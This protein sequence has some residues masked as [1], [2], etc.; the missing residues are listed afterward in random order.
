M[1]D[2]LTKELPSSVG[3]IV[4]AAGSSQRMGNTDKTF[5]PVLGRPLV[6]YSVQ[7]LHDSPLVGEIVLVLSASNLDQ[8]RGLVDENRWN[9]VREVCVGGERRQDSV[10]IGLDRLRHT[11]WTIVHDGARPCIDGEM[12]ARGLAEARKSGAAVAAVPVRDTIKTTGPDGVVSRTL[13]RSGLWTAQT[14]QVFRTELLLRAHRE[15]SDDVTDD[16]SMVEALGVSVSIFTG[17]NGNIKVTTAEDIPIV[18]AILE[19]RRE[20]AAGQRR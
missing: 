4:V 7:A 11:G 16:A 19:A 17:S 8:G 1:A 9:K 10:L 12:V 2:S 20:R 15:I 14:P 18:E 13:D 6:S 5:A 3:A